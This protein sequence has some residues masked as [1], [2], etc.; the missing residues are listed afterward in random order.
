VGFRHTLIAT[1]TPLRVILKTSVSSVW[2]MGGPQGGKKGSGVWLLFFTEPARGTEIGLS[3][4]L[5][6]TTGTIAYSEP[7]FA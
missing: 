2:P 5:V 6:G 7:V 3:S 1:V 4:F